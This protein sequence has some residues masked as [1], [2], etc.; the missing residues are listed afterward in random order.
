MSYYKISCES[1][2]IEGL[3]A[4]QSSFAGQASRVADSNNFDTQVPPPPPQQD[5]ENA[6]AF[7]GAVQPPPVANEADAGLDFS[8]DIAFYQPPPIGADSAITGVGSDR[9]IPPPPKS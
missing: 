3:K 9:E 5:E 7:S 8:R 6:S 1:N 2:T 4:I